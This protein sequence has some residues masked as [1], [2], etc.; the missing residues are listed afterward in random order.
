MDVFPTLS[1]KRYERVRHEIKS[2]DILL[3]SGNSFFSNMIKQATNSTWSHVGFILRLDIID[4]IMILES[5]ES[6]GVRAVPLSS[7]VRD[8][9]G[10]GEGYPGRLM[11]ARHH[12]LK[13]ENIIKLSKFATDLLGYPYSTDS[14]ARIVARI[15]IGSFGF[16]QQD[17]MLPRREFIC[18]EYAHVCFKSVG[19]HVD[20]NQMGFIAP[21]DFARCKRVEALNYVEV[22]E[23]RLQQAKTTAIE[24]VTA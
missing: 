9:N 7:Y 3:C 18:S 10:S 12:D 17:P 16:D 14:I 15:G 22:E 13:Q 19:V 6:I 11:I 21:A 2:G 1:V 4:R 24:K 20:Y 5:V 23:K 8:Y